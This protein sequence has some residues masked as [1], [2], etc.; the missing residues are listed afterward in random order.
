MKR[1]YA[2]EAGCAGF[3]TQKPLLNLR[4]R[5]IR[6]VEFSRLNPAELAETET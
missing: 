6:R 1:T 4:I 3:D 5:R 2:V